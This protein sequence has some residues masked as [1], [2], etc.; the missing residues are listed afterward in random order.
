M[1]FVLGGLRS[2]RLGS[3]ARLNFTWTLGWAEGKRS[4]LGGCAL[5]VL[6]FLVSVSIQGGEGWSSW[7]A[8]AAL[9]SSVTWRFRF[10]LLRSCGQR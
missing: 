9:A 5:E 1:V 4:E 2:S 8:L 3:G 10:S 7:A 6:R